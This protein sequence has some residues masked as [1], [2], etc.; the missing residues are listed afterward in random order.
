MSPSPSRNG[1]RV[2]QA[3]VLDSSSDA[4]SSTTS[5]L[6]DTS[7]QLTRKNLQ[8]LQS[9]LGD[10]TEKVG[11][12]DDVEDEE[13]EMDTEMNVLLSLRERYLRGEGGDGPSRSSS[14][15]QDVHTNTDVQSP[16][17]IS[18]DKD[19]KKKTNADYE[20]LKQ[21]FVREGQAE[22]ANRE[23]QENVNTPPPGPVPQGPQ[24][25]GQIQRQTQTHILPLP[26]SPPLKHKI[27][28]KKTYAEHETLRQRFIRDGEEEEEGGGEKL[29]KEKEKGKPHLSTPKPSPSLSPIPTSAPIPNPASKKTEALLN[30][31]WTRFTHL[32]QKEKYVIYEAYTRSTGTGSRTKTIRGGGEEAESEEEEDRE[33]F[34]K[35]L[36]ERFARLME[37]DDDIGDDRGIGGEEERDDRTLV[38]SPSSSPSVVASSP[39]LPIPLPVPTSTSTSI[40]IFNASPATNEPKG[41]VET[42]V[43]RDVRSLETAWRVDDGEGD[44]WLDVAL[45]SLREER[46]RKEERGRVGEIG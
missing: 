31:Y 46:G 5:T 17:K 25:Q 43:K 38:G 36:R 2:V 44:V 6:T 1:D 3:D 23:S 13:E 4:L 26:P 7:S 27:T 15:R 10:Q 18:T 28:R 20:T 12:E 11:V 37:D 32:P 24:T 30:V 8:M 9:Q 34:L 35:G 29:K 42:R 45:E 21:R 19:E 16:R 33:K 14:V 22:E 40:P 39:T 41:N